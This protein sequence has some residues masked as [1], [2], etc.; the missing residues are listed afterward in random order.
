LFNRIVAA[1]Q[2]AGTRVFCVT[3]LVDMGVDNKVLEVSKIAPV[4]TPLTTNHPHF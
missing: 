3:H 1:L 2:A 4:L